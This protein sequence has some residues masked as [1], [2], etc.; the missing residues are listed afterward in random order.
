MR[1]IIET[2][3]GRAFGIEV[4]WIQRNLKTVEIGSIT[5]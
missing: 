3:A 5:G 4:F 2:P 1:W